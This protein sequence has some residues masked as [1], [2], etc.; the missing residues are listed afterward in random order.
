[1]EGEPTNNSNFLANNSEKY[2]TKNKCHICD[3][4]F[5]QL[6]IHFLEYHSEEFENDEIEEEIEN[7]E[8]AVD[9]FYSE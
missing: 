3:K 7:K 4:D 5:E 2:N 1:M 9:N 6:D 8:T